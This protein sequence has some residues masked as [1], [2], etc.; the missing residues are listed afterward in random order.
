MPQ[1][2]ISFHGDTHEE[3][4]A[5]VWRWVAPFVGDRTVAASAGPSTDQREREVRELLR[6]V[7]GGGDSRRL[8]RELAEAALRGDAVVRDDALKARYG[9]TTGT[10][11]AGMVGGPNKLMRRIGGRDLITWDRAVGGYRIDPLDAEVI[12]AVTAASTA[13]PGSA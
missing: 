9:K 8:I 11:F 13:S 5:S 7:K 1:I 6:R 2:T 4:V 10:A 12:L 3:L